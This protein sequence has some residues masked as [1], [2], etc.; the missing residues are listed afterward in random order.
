METVIIQRRAIRASKD[1]YEG[2]SIKYDCLIPLR[3]CPKN[4]LKPS[5]VHELIGRTLNKNI[6][7]GDIVI[8]DDLS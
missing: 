5:R 7:K 8:L 4:A 1:L 3:P 6:K 2:E